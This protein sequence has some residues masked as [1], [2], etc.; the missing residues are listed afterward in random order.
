MICIMLMNK[1][2]YLFLISF[3]DKKNGLLRHLLTLYIKETVIFVGL[4]R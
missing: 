1:V 3:P 4:G 2:Q